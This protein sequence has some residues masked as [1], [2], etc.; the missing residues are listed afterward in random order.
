MYYI[1]KYYL[2][3]ETHLPRDG[4]LQGC[5]NCEQ[6]TSSTCLYRKFT[7]ADYIYEFYIYKCKTCININKKDLLKRDEFNEKCDDYIE[8]K[9]DYLLSS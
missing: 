8:N 9:F 4:W 2:Y 3:K 1:K 5:F 6:I 7:K